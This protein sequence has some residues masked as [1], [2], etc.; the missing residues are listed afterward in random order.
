MNVAKTFAYTLLIFVI[1]IG[2]LIG[3]YRL[4]YNRQFNALRGALEQNR[5]EIIDQWRHEDISLEDFGFTA[6]TQVG[7]FAIDI[8]D[9]SDVRTPPDRITGI[10]VRFAGKN[11]PEAQP[12]AFDTDYWRSLHLPKMETLADL[13][14]YMPQTLAALRASPPPSPAPE[15][16]R[17]DFPYKPYAVI[18]IPA[19]PATSIPGR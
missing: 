19:P 12:I 17:M 2:G 4:T 10:Y 18:K 13:L 9:G 3:W 15:S 7:D 16:P 5:Y 14:K 8:L 6:R 1:L 11:M